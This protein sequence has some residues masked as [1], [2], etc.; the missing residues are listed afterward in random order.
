MIK[1]I[2]T[3]FVVALGIASFFLIVQLLSNFLHYGTFVFMA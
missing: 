1:R 3:D 2:F